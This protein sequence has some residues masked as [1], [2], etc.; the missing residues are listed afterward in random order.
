MA[1]NILLANSQR[2]ATRVRS[3]IKAYVYVPKY[4]NKNIH[5]IYR[6]YIYLFVY[7]STLIFIRPR[8]TK[9]GCCPYNF[10]KAHPIPPSPP[11]V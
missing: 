10:P 2:V 4:K 8:M 11:R 7:L 3:F 6:R 1:P 9:S 5:Y